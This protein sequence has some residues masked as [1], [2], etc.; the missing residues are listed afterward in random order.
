V[1]KHVSASVRPTEEHL[2]YL[3]QIRDS[4]IANMFGVAPWLQSKFGLSAEDARHVL[5]SW[6]ETYAERH[7][8]RTSL[9]AAR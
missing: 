2:R 8:R 6:M 5:V 3:D 9:G 7:P 4:G 1:A